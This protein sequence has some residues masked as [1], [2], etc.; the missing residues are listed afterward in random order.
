MLYAKLRHQ[1]WAESHIRWELP[2]STQSLCPVC[3][4]VIEA[5]LYE[6]KNRVFMHKACG[7]HGSFNE[8][9][10]SDAKFFKGLRRRHYEMPLGIENPN[11][12]NRSHCPRECGLCE[13]HLSTPAMVNIDLTNRCNQNCPICFA[14]S[15]ASGRLYEVT[16]EQVKM[17][18]DAAVS[19]K[20]H[21]AACLQYVGGEPT[22]YPHF[23]EALREAK[24]R[25]FTQIQVASNGVR[26]AKSLEFTQAAAQA[27]LEVVYLQFDGLDDEI[28]L[29]TRGRRLV[30]TKLKAIENMRKSYLRV[31]LVPT[32]VKGINDRHVGEILRFAID[33]S[34]IMTG[35][36]WQPVA[37]TGRIDES[38]RMQMRFTIAD[39]ARSLAEQTGFFDMYRDW[40]PFSV[41]IPF[42]RLLEAVTGRPSMRCSCSAH[43]GC[44]TYL[45]VDKQTKKAVPLPAFLDIVPAMEMLNKIAERIE[46]HRWV[47]KASVLQATKSLKRYF[48]QERAPEG[49]GFE[50][51][52]EFIRYFAE[53]KEQ[54][55]DT[56]MRS[57]QLRRDRFATMLLAAMHFQD[58]YN[59]E[60]DRVRH[61][62]ILY[63]A[64]NGRFY[65][66]CSWNSGLCHRRQI[67]ST[68]SRQLPIKQI[69]QGLEVG[70]AVALEHTAT[71]S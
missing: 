19:I 6:D 14:N 33:N 27:G 20:P 41:T 26:F 31:V 62:V 51:L 55:A 2:A 25:G 42:A 40:Y 3:L 7:E 4:E 35:I 71:K 43:C 64:P 9:I 54:W 66:F 34:D 58:S 70:E 8:L 23:L 15:N 32:I 45:I 63:A 1:R 60:I 67:E 39:L 28:Y 38:K 17:M 59:Y 12:E 16:I 53:F 69:E 10:S 30:E 29:K 24:S 37:I 22:I 11:C 47:K 52:L 61:C 48:H 49:W 56:K 5:E 21:S 57:E 46:N 13:Q 68:Y 65:P 36:S 18:L 50:R 44:A